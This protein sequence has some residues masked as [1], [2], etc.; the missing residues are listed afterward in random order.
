MK[1]LRF[2]PEENSKDLI[3]N[4]NYKKITIMAYE[5][6]SKKLDGSRVTIFEND[7]PIWTQ[8]ITNPANTIVYN[9]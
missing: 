9:F 5:G 3:I 7:K 2:Y 4:K 6:Q 8:L 1:R